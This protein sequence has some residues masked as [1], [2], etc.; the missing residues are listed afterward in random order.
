MSQFFKSKRNEFF[1]IAITLL[2]FIAFYVET[3]IYTPSFP[4]MMVYFNS[5]EESI[6]KI[7]S[8]NFLGLCL[9]S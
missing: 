1:F 2:G 3:D 4:E 6:Q 8:M 5:T 9:A 7:L